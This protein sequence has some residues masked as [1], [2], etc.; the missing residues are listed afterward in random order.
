MKRGIVK[1]SN[2]KTGRKFRFMSYFYLH[3]KAQD[4][5]NYDCCEGD[6]ETFSD[7]LSMSLRVVDLLMKNGDI[8]PCILLTTVKENKMTGLI[9]LCDDLKGIK[10]AWDYFNKKPSLTLYE[11]DEKYLKEYFPETR[12]LIS[13]LRRK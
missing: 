6:I 1:C 10:S 2:W 11:H 12:Q 13:E 4:I 7:V 8:F 9:C 3:C 5:N